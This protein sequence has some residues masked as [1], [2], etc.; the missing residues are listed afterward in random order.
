MAAYRTVSKTQGDRLTTAGAT[1]DAAIVT[2]AGLMT[3]KLD[4]SK[5][6]DRRKQKQG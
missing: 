6:P 2:L 5:L 4:S 1:L 3:I